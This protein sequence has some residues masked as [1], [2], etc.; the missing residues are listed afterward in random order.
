MDSDA[1]DVA[2]TSAVHNQLHL[3]SIP[4]SNQPQLQREAELLKIYTQ[5][6][7]P[8]LDACDD[9]RQFTLCVPRLAL[10]HPILRQ[11][12]LAAASRYD[13][14]RH[15]RESLE[16]T[17]YHSRC[18]E[19]I[20]EALARDPGTYD[21]TVLAAV[22][23]SRTYEE[24]DDD[25]RHH[26]LSGTRNLLSQEAVARS[27]HDGGLAEAAS[28]IHLRQSIYV[29]L[30]KGRPVDV[31]LRIY[32]TVPVLRGD[33]AVANRAVYLFAKILEAFLNNYATERWAELENELATWEQS[34]PDAFRP[35]YQ[36]EGDTEVEQMF[37][38][39]YML[40]TVSGKPR[41]PL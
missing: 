16:G 30:V 36:D 12:I 17:F 25:Q 29:S 7:G 28:W 2:N 5:H 13:S 33:S 26:H 27:V 11:G 15:C 41:L 32:E 40:S 39:I 6:L 19:L 10:Q 23:I 9:S 20:I 1:G 3:P 22:V 8:L 18:I 38:R 21:S 4:P 35:I 34:K 14:L 24:M 37:P 31:P